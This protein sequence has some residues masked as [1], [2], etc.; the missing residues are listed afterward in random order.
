MPIPIEM[1]NTGL[2]RRVMSRAAG[3]SGLA[4]CFLAWPSHAHEHD[5]EGAADVVFEVRAGTDTLT[6]AFRRQNAQSVGNQSIAAT[7]V[8]D[9]GSQPAQGWQL[10]INHQWCNDAR[11][12][13][14][15]L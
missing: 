10:R 4:C 15:A 3:P 2:A 11:V 14:T 1:A 12:E 5:I 7:A 6:N 13:V 9:F 8:L